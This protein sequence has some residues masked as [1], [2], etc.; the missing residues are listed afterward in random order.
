MC[1]S[2][3]LTEAE[4][5]VSLKINQKYSCTL[6]GATRNSGIPENDILK[7]Q[8]PEYIFCA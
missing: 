7:A 3:W 8:K 2:Q 6:K 1:S 5:H 4:A